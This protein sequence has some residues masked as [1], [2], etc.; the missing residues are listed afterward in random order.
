MQGTKPHSNQ[1]TEVMEITPTIARQWIQNGF[2]STKNFIQNRPVSIRDV[3]RLAGMMRSGD[4]ACNGES[5]KLND[6]EQVWDGQH[7]LLAVVQSGVTIWSH[8]GFH[9]PESA[10]PTCDRDNPRTVAHVLHMMGVKR[11]NSVGST[12]SKIYRHEKHYAGLFTNEIAWG[13][14]RIFGIE[15]FMVPEF[16]SARPE[17]IDATLYANAKKSLTRLVPESSVG[18]FRYLTTRTPEDLPLS[19]VFLSRI[20]TGIGLEEGDAS[21]ACRERLQRM[22]EKNKSTGGVFYTAGVRTAT[23]V[24]GWNFWM[25][26]RDVRQLRYSPNER[27]PR[28][29][30][31]EDLD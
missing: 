29:L 14:G 12:L 15:P 21:Y 26:G 16:M 11:A 25:E 22:T 9:I 4:W 19:D 7:R 13:N 27:W 6:R 18:A 5:I 24:K 30:L 2:P 17:I 20:I 8:V 28:L 31:S 1:R 23:L 10:L 3:D